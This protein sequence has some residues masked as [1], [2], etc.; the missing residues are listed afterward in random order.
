M[1]SYLFLFITLLLVS[2]P[3]YAHGAPPNSVLLGILLVYFLPYYIGVWLVGKGNRLGFSGFS[4]I[5]YIISFS[6][7]IFIGDLN[8]VGVFAIISPYVLIIVA[9]I[10]RKRNAI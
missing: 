9:F 6:L 5:L 10:S 2:S 1:S 8:P 7:F 3:V 4:L